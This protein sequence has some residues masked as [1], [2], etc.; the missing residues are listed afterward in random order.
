M[1]RTPHIDLLARQGVRFETAV[2]NT[3][4][5]SPARAALLAGQ[6]ARTC[7]GSVVNCGFEAPPALRQR[8]PSPTLA[9]TLQHAGYHTELIGK[10]HTWDHPN[11]CGFAH[12]MHAMPPHRH[13]GQRYFENE[14]LDG[15]VVEQFAPEYEADC[16]EAFLAERA[17][18]DEPFFLHYN[19]GPP[20]MPL[21]PGNAPQR[22]L[23]MY[24]PQEVPLRENVYDDAGRPAFDETWFKIYTIWDYFLLYFAGEAERPTDRMPDGMTLRSLTAWYLGMT[25]L[26]DELVGRVL[27]ALRRNGMDRQTL[28]VFVSDH[29]DNLGSHQMFNKNVL[30]DE[31]IRIPL[32]F[33]LPDTLNPLTAEK[34]VAQTIDVAP[35]V[36]SLLGLSAPPSMQGRDL[37]PVMRGET[38]SLADRAAIVESPDGGVGIRTPRHMLGVAHREGFEAPRRL[39][40][41]PYMLYDLQ[42]DPLQ[43]HNLV[44]DPD[45]KALRDDLF[46]R[47][48]AWDAS[49]PW[50]TDKEP[51]I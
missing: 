51:N 38:S 42:D 50:L 3:P 2:S 41:K 15:F 21:G 46:A 12:S 22:Y 17:N 33:H 30:L 45:C 26:I 16:V 11:R 27:T 8:F 39:A 10:W 9:E 23:D 14:D 6:H 49:T 18:H 24:D 7:V 20:H 31:S 40:E 34:Q 5:C 1:V 43:T 25:T 13:Y 36:L 35:T 48:R 32:V 4:V 47:V 29:G 44:D 19:P 28:V 37:T